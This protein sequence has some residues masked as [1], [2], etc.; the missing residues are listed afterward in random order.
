MPF[1]FEW[2]VLL[3]APLVGGTVAPP[4]PLFFSNLPRK[5]KDLK[6]KIIGSNVLKREGWLGLGEL[7]VYTNGDPNEL[8]SESM[9]VE[10]IIQALI[11]PVFK[12]HFGDF[13]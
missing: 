3:E 7:F 1:I 2:E 5:E 10:I 8:T 12:P 11:C 6:K 4:L 9:E 13:I